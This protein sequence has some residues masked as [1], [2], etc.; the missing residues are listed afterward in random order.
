M[1]F[2]KI[3]SVITAPIIAV[4]F[5][6]LKNKYDKNKY[7][8]LLKCF[9]GGIFTVALVLIAE[10]IAS[11]YGLD[12]LKSFRRVIFYSFIIVG[13]SSEFAKYLLLRFYAFPKDEFKGPLDSIIYSTM[14]SLGFVTIGNILYVLQYENIS[15]L[16]AFT[17]I[18]ANMIFAVIMGYFVGLAKTRKNLFIDSM[19]GLFIAILFHGLF[20]FCFLTPDYTLLLLTFIGSF[21]ISVLLLI[22]A[23]RLKLAKNISE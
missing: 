12:N 8:L 6:L 21:L 3:L 7:S 9:F 15:L 16:Y 11:Y 2:L 22:Q 4:I 10:Y 14:I 1:I 13:F 18:P 19:T 20:S 17:V 23:I 5:V